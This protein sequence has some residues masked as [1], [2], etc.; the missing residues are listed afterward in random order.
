MTFVLLSVAF[1]ASATAADWTVPQS[2]GRLGNLRLADP[3]VSFD[4][5]GRGLFS[6]NLATEGPGC[7]GRCGSTIVPLAA[8]EPA[9]T[10]RTV[11]GLVNGPVLFGRG[12]AL[13][14]RETTHDSIA[15]LAAAVGASTGRAGRWTRLD[16]FPAVAFGATARAAAT[17]AGDLAVTWI[18]VK[19]PQDTGP[20]RLASRRAGTNAWRVMTLDPRASSEPTI[21]ATGTRGALTVIYRQGH[22][23]RARAR[24]ASGRLGPID[25]VG[26]TG[27]SSAVSVSAGPHG[28]L[29]A[30]WRDDHAHHH[31]IRV[32]V[33]AGGA[34]R[35]GPVRTVVSLTKREVAD[36]FT[37]I[38]RAGRPLVGYWT[39]RPYGQELTRIAFLDGPRIERVAVGVSGERL[40]DLLVLP[41]GETFLAT[42]GLSRGLVIH[43]A[44]AGT[45]RFSMDAPIRAN[46]PSSVKLA[47]DPGSR[48]LAIAF[49]ARAPDSPENAAYLAR[50]HG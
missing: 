50:R 46:L 48:N 7:R 13:F 39:F 45:S 23:I 4:G 11:A 24:Y 41:T 12:H 31:A 38:D 28:Q 32:S 2:L 33:R 35:F 37:A 14:V 15:S 44:P 22:T 19:R 49:V 9:G 36:P 18:H 25:D 29:V 10:P 5:V 40:A 8:G 42:L 20:L 30:A 21:V 17:S 1:P 26:P 27:P 43:R 34:A 3:T 6:W 16:R 47:F